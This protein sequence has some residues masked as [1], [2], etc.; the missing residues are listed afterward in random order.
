ML[1][2]GLEPRSPAWKFPQTQLF[3]LRKERLSFWQADHVHPLVLSCE[4][5]CYQELKYDQPPGNL[6]MMPLTVILPDRYYQAHVAIKCQAA[7]PPRSAPSLPL[8]AHL[9][10]PPRAWLPDQ[11]AML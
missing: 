3:D 9:L 7:S 10:L 5:L 6:P 11:P 2:S 4:V 8:S 1:E